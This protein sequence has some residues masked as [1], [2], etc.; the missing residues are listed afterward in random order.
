MKKFIFLISSFFLFYS[1]GTKNEYY[2]IPKNEKPLYKL[3][4]TL[5]YKSNGGIKDT[6]VVNLYQDD[7]KVSDKRYHYE[8]ILIQFKPLNKVRYPYTYIGIIDQGLKGV[9]IGWLLFNY[10]VN[11]IDKEPYSPE[12]INGR[13][14]EKVYKLIGSQSLWYSDTVKAVYYNQQY[15]IVKYIMIDGTSWELQ[16]FK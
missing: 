6:F 10:T 2:N 7:Y 1:C 12:T 14:F 16:N 3:H 13:T 8:E 5:I 4:D 11:P 15:C 9:S